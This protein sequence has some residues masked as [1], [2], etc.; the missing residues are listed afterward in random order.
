MQDLI[1]N[2]NSIKDK[3]YTIRN[4]Q[5]MLDRDLAELYGVETKRI[6]EAV[7]NNKDKFM[8]DFYFELN[9]FEFEFLRSKISTTSFIKTRTNPKVF[10]EQGIYMLATILKSKVASQVTIN[11]IKTFANMRKLISQN[12]ALFERFERIENR[13]TI[14]DKNFNV[15]FKALEDK[16]N[17]P[18]QNIFFDGQI[19]DAYSF[20]NDLI[21]LANSEIVLIDN[22][23]DDTVFTL[24]SKYP[25][26]NFIIYTNNISKQLKLDFEKYS[27]QYK[28][29]ALK[30]F[31]SSH[32][33][34][35]IIDKKDIYHLGASLK[36][37]GK[38]WFAF[39][40]MS[41][42]SLNLDEIFNRLK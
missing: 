30:T 6:N 19:Y 10:T 16:N 22:Y 11:L 28:N 26:I 42:D 9:D 21:K 20:V 32:D 2:E 12:I 14:H 17:I 24:F 38:K 23:I 41:L 29:I 7:K 34:F 27:K 5:V 1:I 15:L 36:D 4:M 37:L 31:K 8:D 13:L 25:N 3:I 33:R 40:K 39:S 18:V 35:L